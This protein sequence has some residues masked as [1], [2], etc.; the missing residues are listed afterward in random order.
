MNCCSSRIKVLIFSLILV[1][2]SAFGAS[3]LQTDNGKIEITEVTLPMPKGE[4]LNVLIFRPENATPESPAPA[5]IT[6]HGYFNSKEMQDIT[7]I[8]LA[9]RGFVV[10]SM[11]MYAHGFSSGTREPYLYNREFY[12]LGMSDLVDYVHDRIEYV[13]PNRIGITGHSTGARMVSYVLD[14]Y[15]RSEKRAKGIKDGAHYSHEPFDAGKYTKKVASALLVANFPAAYLIENI[16]D[17]INV[18]ISMA[19]YDEGAPM[20][21]TKLDGYFWSD[22]SISPEAKNFINNSHPN[23]FKLDKSIDYK[24]ESGKPTIKFSNWDNNE[25]VEIGKFYGNVD[26][27]NVRVIYNPREIHPWNHF[28][29]VSSGIMTDYFTAT[30]GAPNP[31]PAEEQTWFYKELFNALGLL[32]F[33]IFVLQVV[34]VLLCT[35]YFSTIKLEI[36]EKRH[37]LTSSGASMKFFGGLLL[38]AIVAGASVMPFMSLNTTIFPNSLVQ[39]TTTWFSQPSTNQ[40]MLWALFNG[41]FAYIMLFFVY[42]SQKKDNNASPS[43]WGLK[44]SSCALVK[45]IVLAVLVVIIAY[46]LIAM[47][48]MFFKTDFRIWTLAVKKINAEMVYTMLRYLPFFFFFYLANSIAVNGANRVAGQNECV[49]TFYCIVATVGGLLAM[50][51]IQYYVLLTTGEAIWHP[52]LSWIN[53]LLLIPM[54]PFLS[55]A[56][57]YTRKIF[58]KTGSVYL[59]AL[60]NALLF[61]LITAANTTN[62]T[63]LP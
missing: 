46:T 58:N 3:Y 54:V 57:I 8:E 37:A 14:A 45:T 36:P 1:L 41:L 44:I 15:E 51:I 56:V 27:K 4:E 11:D 62:I 23:T 28:S 21:L 52:N 47:V 18:G 17:D 16:P 29:S 34:Y 53:I 35:E 33:F 48:D 26:D 60:L 49:N 9:K 12:G 20:Q 25:K 5:V 38:T 50:I 6:S 7:S 31:M 43:L 22:L 40:V 55:I 42:S 13:D 24:T 39:N 59:G 19:Y 32:G 10:F 2:I 30:L 61:T 63:T